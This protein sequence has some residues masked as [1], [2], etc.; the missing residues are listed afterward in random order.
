MHAVDTNVLVRFLTR[1]DEQQA[2][3]AKKLLESSEIFVS[4][5]VLLELDWVLR[6]LYRRDHSERH[7]VFLALAGARNVFVEDPMA[8]HTALDLFGK[9]MDFADA[10]H[11][12]ASSQTEGF[13]TFDK[14]LARL[15]A[16]SGIK[17]V[18]ELAGSEE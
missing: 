17:N 8:V 11:L 10:L 2:R 3:K 4:K 14:Q 6:S 13:Y 1:D 18:L 16:Q 5:T 15:A 12:A 7:K 9:G